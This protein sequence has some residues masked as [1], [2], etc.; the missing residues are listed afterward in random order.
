MQT[1]LP[2]AAASSPAPVSSCNHHPAC[3]SVL[4]PMPLAPTPTASLRVRSA[5]LLPRDR[6]NKTLHRSRLYCSAARLDSMYFD[7]P[8][9]AAEALSFSAHP[10]VRCFQLLAPSNVPE[11]M[12]S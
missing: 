9:D 12:D 5:F 11:Q 6:A 10:P 7:A 8:R 2:M 4:N 1:R 3:H